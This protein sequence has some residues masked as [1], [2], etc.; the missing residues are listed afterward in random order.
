V[1][2]LPNDDLPIERRLPPELFAAA[3]EL[4]AG[5][6][7]KIPWWRPTWRDGLRH[8]GWRWIFFMPIVGVIGFAVAAY[9]FPPL[10]NLIIPF[11]FKFMLFAGG[12]AIS[13]VGYVLRQATKA[14]PEPFC[15]HCGYNLTGLPDNYRCPECGRPYSWRVIDEYRRDP[16]WF[17]TR[18]KASHKLPENEPTLEAGPGPRRKSRD[19]T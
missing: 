7:E 8:L 4:K 15:I 19:G 5:P 17:V 14:R 12:I 1:Q 11:G 18:W 6:G 9:W 3:G 16:Q 10:L 2:S 13:L